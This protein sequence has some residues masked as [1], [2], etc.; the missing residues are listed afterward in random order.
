MTSLLRL[1]FVSFLAIGTLTACGKRGHLEPPP[2]SQQAAS[3]EQKAA[4]AAQPGQNTGQTRLGG[5][6]RTPITP[7][8]R[9]LIIDGILD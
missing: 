7:P 1:T 6:K 2:G 3:G 5:S 4:G 8:K 9:D